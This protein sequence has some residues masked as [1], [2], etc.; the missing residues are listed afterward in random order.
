MGNGKIL[1]G[2]NEAVAWTGGEG[3][4][5]VTMPGQ[6]ARD[7][8]F[9]EF[10]LEHT[11]TVSMQGKTVRMDFADEKAAYALFRAATEAE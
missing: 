9:S 4:L 3:T 2:L 8:T 7:M 6:P 5:R 11:P 1:Q 10:M